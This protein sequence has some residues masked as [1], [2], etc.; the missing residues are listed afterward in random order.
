[1][2]VFGRTPIYL[3]TGVNITPLCKQCRQRE[4]E[5]RNGKTTLQNEEYFTAYMR[6]HYGGH[7]PDIEPLIRALVEC[8]P[9]TQNQVV[10]AMHD[11]IHESVKMRGWTIGVYSALTIL[12]DTALTRNSFEDNMV[13]TRHY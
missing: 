11:L 8:T 9:K 3:D 2:S 1:M 12:Y 6:R 4:H 10:S 5:N 7:Q 13:T